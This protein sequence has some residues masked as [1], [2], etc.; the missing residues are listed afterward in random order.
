[1]PFFLA[2]LLI[3]SVMPA[4]TVW[5]GEYEYKTTPLDQ[6]WDWWTTLGKS[7]MEKDRIWLKIMPSASNG[8]RKNSRSR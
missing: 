3:S 5:A 2:L 8:M 4:V 6:A 1:M 7:G